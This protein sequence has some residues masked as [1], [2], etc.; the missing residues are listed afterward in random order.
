M[1]ITLHSNNQPYSHE[2]W[3]HD[4]MD[5]LMQATAKHGPL[6][7][8]LIF[9][10]AEFEN[11]RDFCS[12]LSSMPLLHEL[13]L[14]RVKFKVEEDITNEKQAMLSKLNKLTVNT[15]DWNIFKFF[16]TA[17]IKELQISNRFSIVD[18]QQRETYMKFLEASDKLESI[19]L[20]LMSYAK[21]FNIPM[22]RNIRFKLRRL[23]YL[24]FSPSYEIDNIDRNFGTFLESQASS[25][26]ELNLNYVSPN[27]TKIIFTKLK[28]LEKLRLNA[29]VLPNNTE[30][31]GCFKKMN[32]LKELILHDDIAS[33][34]A[35]KEILVNCCNLETLTAHYDPLHYISNLLTFIAANMPMLKNLSLDTLSVVM[36]PEVRFNHLKFLH[37]QTC[38]NLENLIKFLNNN[39]VIE[40][41]SLNLADELIIPDDAIL[42]ALLN[43]SSLHHLIVAAGDS[44]LN[45]IYSKIKVDY[46]KLKSLELRPLTKPGDRVFIKFPDDKLDWQPKELLFKYEN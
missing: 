5:L 10:H 18:V 21:T 46:R 22:D 23:K 14:N 31:Y 9:K 44:A 3:T 16:M 30:F 34:I 26:T 15:C 37:I 42:E 38:I 7:R 36:A 13:T 33:D 35:V 43:R 25:L 4:A 40:T 27:V 41:L 24:S 29:V 32:H 17:P 45:T 11:I 39:A 1:S 28:V 20:D 2:T 8:K 6:I 12:V 19:E